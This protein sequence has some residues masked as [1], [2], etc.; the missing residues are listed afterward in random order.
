MDLMVNG[1]R[2]RAPRCPVCGLADMVRVLEFEDSWT[3]ECERC[4]HE[5]TYDELMSAE[6]E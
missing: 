3:Y 4:N 6:E 1:M 2:V 5:I